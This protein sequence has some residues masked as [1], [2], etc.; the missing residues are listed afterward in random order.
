MP[1]AP[2]FSRSRK[3]RRR[4]A[5][6]ATK[7]VQKLLGLDAKLKQYQQG[8]SFIAYVERELGP[9]AAAAFTETKNVFLST[10]E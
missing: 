8:E 7:L 5:G 4:Q 2:R 9:D 10:E 3:E 1:S 6:G